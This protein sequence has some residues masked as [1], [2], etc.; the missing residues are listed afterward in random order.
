MDG[1]E[2]RAAFQHDPAGRRAANENI[3]AVH[4]LDLTRWDERI[5]WDPD[6]VPFAFFDGDRVVAL[7]CIYVLDMIVRREWRRVAQVSSVATLPE[8]RMRGLNAELTRRAMEWCREQNLRGVFL[9]SD[10]DATGFYAKQGFVEQ[11]EWK[12]RIDVT[13]KPTPGSRTLGYDQDEDLVVRLVTTRT[14]VSH[15]LGVRTSRLELFHLLYGYA[16]EMRYVEELDLIVCCEEEVGVLSVYDLIGPELLSW[17][18]I[19]PYVISEDTRRIE[20]EITP[21]R[22][23]LEGAEPVEHRASRLHVLPGDELIRGQVIVPY[24]AHA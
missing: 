23:A 5:G 12:H 14:P 16:G 21:D 18:N 11:S 7:T 17:R 4:E 1:L 10:D 24:T 9:F 6:Y 13:S 2:Y 19:E 3:M 15:L 20:F 22:L 8:Y